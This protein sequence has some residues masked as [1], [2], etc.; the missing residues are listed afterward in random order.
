MTKTLTKAVF[1]FLTILVLPAVMPH[2]WAVDRPVVW[3]FEFGHWNLFVICFLV[4]G[5]SF[6]QA[7]LIDYR[8]K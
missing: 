8:S 5:I 1:R 3:N 6:K 2:A 4:L 7:K